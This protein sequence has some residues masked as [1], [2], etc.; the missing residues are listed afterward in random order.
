MQKVQRQRENTESKR[1]GT[2]FDSQG[3][4][5][6]RYLKRGASE[7]RPKQDF[8]AYM[9]QKDPQRQYGRINT[10][11]LWDSKTDTRRD[12]LVVAFGALYY[13]TPLSES[14]AQEHSTAMKMCDAGED[15][16]RPRISGNTH[17]LSMELRMHWKCYVLGVSD[18]DIDL[19]L[20]RY[21]EFIDDDAF[22]D[23]ETALQ[24]LVA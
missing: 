16:M 3:L 8:M 1:L 17:I 12:A 21:A 19:V 24:S 20:L 22:V 10:F 4:R 15:S 9:L 6:F 23:Y 13:G 5:S 11:P 7:S 2:A 14:A 18:K